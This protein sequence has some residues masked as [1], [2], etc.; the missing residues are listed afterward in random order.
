MKDTRMVYTDDPKLSQRCPKCKEYLIECECAP[1]VD[2]SKIDFNPVLRI[3]KSGRAGKVVTVID[4]L[5]GNDKYLK[6]LSKTLKTRCGTGG[7]YRRDG[8]NGIIEIQGDKREQIRAI[9]KDMNII[10]KG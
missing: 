6:E 10:C 2:P 5:P 7:T 3:E 4:K 8:T 1:Q 9:L